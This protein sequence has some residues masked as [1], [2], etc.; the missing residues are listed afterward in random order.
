MPCV[1]DQEQHNAICH[2]KRLPTNLASLYPVLAR[3]MQGIIE[4]E[5][6]RLKTDPMFLQICLAL[7][8]IPV[9]QYWTLSRV[10]T[11]M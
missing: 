1:R 7:L 8:F 6:S 11:P 5:L 2:A 10:A 3:N 4:H 9:D